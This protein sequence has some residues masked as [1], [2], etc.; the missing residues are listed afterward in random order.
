MNVKHKRIVGGMVFVPILLLIVFGIS[1]LFGFG[2]V[3]ANH[4]K[5]KTDWIVSRIYNYRCLVTRYDSCV[6][7][8]MY[9]EMFIPQYLDTG[10]SLQMR[11]IPTFDPPGVDS[12]ADYMN[13]VARSEA[14]K[15]TG[16]TSLSLFRMIFMRY[17]DTTATYTVPDTTAWTIELWD[18]I[19]DQK[20]E[21]I[22]SAGIY[23]VTN[24][25]NSYFPSTF[26]TVDTSKGYEI[27]TIDL[28]TYKSKYRLDS[29]YLRLKI[30]NW[31]QASNDYC[32][33]YDD[34]STNTKFTEKAI[35]YSEC[36]GVKLVGWNYPENKNLH[37]MIEE[38]G[39]HPITCL[40]TLSGSEKRVLVDRGIILCKTIRDDKTALEH[41]G[42]KGERADAVV[43][44]AEFFCPV[45][46]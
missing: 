11:W 37:N 33:L 41:I 22:D 8:C 12:T 5:Q 9:G 30:K 19:T 13:S 28:G 15:L 43:K 31:D 24:A 3:F 2:F 18:K 26:G 17:D 42:I 46:S 39:L 1:E 29:V 10:D 32:T 14:F 36:S 45:N 44:E 38:A 6:V 25:P 20:V 27:F 23:P 4:S 34:I 35:K 40:T 7:A 21:T 16:T